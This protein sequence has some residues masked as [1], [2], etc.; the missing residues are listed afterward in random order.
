[1]KAGPGDEARREVD[2]GRQPGH[3]IVGEALR[4]QA[5]CAVAVS[6]DDQL[7]DHRVVGVISSL[8]ST[9]VST[10]TFRL[11]VGGDRRANAGCRAGNIA[12]VLGVDAR[13]RRVAADLQLFLGERQGW[14]AATR[15]CHHSTKVLA[16]D[17]FGN[18]VL[19]L[20]A[21]IHLHEVEQAVR[22]KCW[23]R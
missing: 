11:S 6:S 3:L 5:E 2:I 17:H 9:P 18:R 7:S 20:Q 1:M 15:N 12:G 4:M 10:R 13:L 8:S 22:R 23:S 14:P 16:S 21:G 19:H